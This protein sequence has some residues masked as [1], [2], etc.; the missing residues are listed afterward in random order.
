M[1][2]RG[3]I[4]WN[5][6]NLLSKRA[7]FPQ[8]ETL[9]KL[10][11]RHSLERSLM[12]ISQ[13][14][15]SDEQINQ[16]ISWLERVSKFIPIPSEK[17]LEEII[18]IMIL[19]SHERARL[20][21][22]YDYPGLELMKKVR[23]CM[24]RYFVVLSEIRASRKEYISHWFL[25]DYW[26]F[27]WSNALFALQPSDTLDEHTFPDLVVRDLL[28]MLALE[29]ACADSV[30]KLE[31]PMIRMQPLG[32]KTERFILIPTHVAANTYDIQVSKILKGELT[33]T[34]WVEDTLKV[35]KLYTIK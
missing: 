8:K 28:H 12:K 25:E 29:L 33:F 18:R 2:Q 10:F 14:E 11:N 19:L 4:E 30:S 7:E 26:M 22:L 6:K 20:N 9:D 15:T 34:E 13:S 21:H 31:K 32:D 35:Y 24:I 16:M 17:E 23:E 27:E 1:E 3:H 5:V